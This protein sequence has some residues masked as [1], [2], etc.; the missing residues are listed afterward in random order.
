MATYFS[1][2]VQRKAK[3]KKRHPATVLNAALKDFLRLRSAFWRGGQELATVKLSLR[4]PSLNPPQN[5]VL[6]TPWKGTQVQNPLL[7]LRV[8]R[9]GLGFLLIFLPHVLMPSTAAIGGSGQKVSERR[10]FAASSFAPAN[11]EER[12]VARPK[13]VL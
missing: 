1:L 2:L 11:G 8:P 6:T 4:H 13:E 5:T 10:L 12:R 7:N 9:A 3:Q